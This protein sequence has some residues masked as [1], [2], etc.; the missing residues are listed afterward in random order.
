[1]DVYFGHW[2]SVEAQPV[3]VVGSKD[4]FIRWLTT[5]ERGS[6]RYALRRFTINPGGIIP[7]HTHK[8]EE[9]LYILSGR[10]VVCAGETK[11]SVGADEYVYIG[12]S[13]PHALIN[14]GNTLF[15]FLCIIPYIEDMRIERSPATC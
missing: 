13:V 8:Y 15:E 11:R 5:K 12:G 3:S 10:G 2:R 7:M 4:A 9:T 6:T 1:M 14:D